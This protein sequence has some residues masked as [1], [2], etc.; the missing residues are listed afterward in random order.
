MTEVTRVLD[1]LVGGAP[2]GR[3]NWQD[4][5]ARSRELPRRRMRRP[6]LVAAA[7]LVLLALAGTAVGV[8]VSLLA[9]QKRFHAEFPG[10]PDRIGPLV[11][12]TSGDS[13]ALIAWRS[14]EGLCLDFAVPDNSP[15]RCGF[16]VRGTGSSGAGQGPP[17]H[18]VAGFLSGS[19][20][21]GV[22][23]GKA[24]MFGVA[25]K[26]VS[27]VKVELSDGRLINT[28]LFDAPPRL[29]YPV[30]LFIVRFSFGDL[31]RTP[32]GGVR[33]YRAYDASG[34]LMERVSIDA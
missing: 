4:V 9:Q 10:T 34:R 7:L 32:E 20:L 21:V 28:E 5:V 16:P 31:E 22:S 18:A 30:K 33:A 13:W 8:S 14:K 12:I 24:T 6:M 3:A 27:T 11:Q 23:D 1:E 17:V 19:N 15:F 29:V 26:N 2:V 25:A